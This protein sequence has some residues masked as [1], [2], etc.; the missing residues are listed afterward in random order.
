MMQGANR[1]LRAVS[2]AANLSQ[3]MGGAKG[4]I[5]IWS[6]IFITFGTMVTVGLV[7]QVAVN[8]RGTGQTMENAGEYFTADAGT[9]AVVADAMLGRD[10][11]APS[12]AIPTVVLNNRTADIVINT[13]VPGS[14][15]ADVYRYFDPG[16]SG[17][18]SSL[19]AGARYIFEIN[20]VLAQSAFQVNWAFTPAANSWTI[21]LYE[22]S[23]TGGA[24]V[25]TGSGQASPGFLNISA[26]QLAGGTYTVDFYN[27]SPSTITSAS[28]SAQGGPGHTW[29]YTQAK[30]DYQIVSSV[31]YVL[32]D[33]Y[34]RQ[35]PGPSLTPLATP[36]VSTISWQISAP[37]PPPTPTPTPT[38]I[39]GITPTPTFTPTPTP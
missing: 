4:Y 34:V 11:T 37:P 17:T 16:V 26:G 30:K 23:G 14:G 24:V 25:A 7:A 29:I 31:G 36:F 3:K 18:L 33:A 38:P 22:G 20:G 39:P 21:T 10:I 1:F 6:I 8:L 13:P 28:Y 35:E 12:Y 19:P 15:S 27:T 9:S 32:L 5:L 2:R